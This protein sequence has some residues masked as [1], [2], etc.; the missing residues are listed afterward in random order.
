VP[1]ISLGT[2]LT[3]PERMALGSETILRSHVLQGQPTKNILP[4][5]LSAIPFE[6]NRVH[7]GYLVSL[8]LLSSLLDTAR[9]HFLSLL[10]RKTSSQITME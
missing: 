2:G 6:R 1:S 4:V 7:S 10:K 8:D 5:S 3:T 9:L